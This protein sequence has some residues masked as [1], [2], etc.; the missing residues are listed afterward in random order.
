M[1]TEAADELFHVGSYFTKVFI[2]ATFCFPSGH[3]G[4]ARHVSQEI[5]EYV[6]QYHLKSA[7][8][9]ISNCNVMLVG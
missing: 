2:T 3:F 4:K 5:S 7:L 9:W 6:S 8:T 1:S